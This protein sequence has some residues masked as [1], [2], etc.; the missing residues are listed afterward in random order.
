MYRF[1]FKKLFLFFFLILV[2]AA[3]FSQTASIR[4]FVYEK[5]SGEPV[6]FTNVFLKGTTFGAATDVNGYFSITKIPPGEYQLTVQALGF[7]SLGVIINLKA[8]EILTKKLFVTK[9]GINIKTIDVTAESQ[10]KKSD[11]KMSVTKITP[12]EIKVIP[13]VGG[14]P[15]LAQFIQVLP[16]VVFTGDQGGQL[17]IRGGTPIQNKVLLD[18]MIIYNP[19][20][21]IGM[22]SVFDTDIIRNTDVYTGGFGAEYGGRISS[23]MD[24]KTRDGNKKR[25]GG[26]VSA[27][28]FSAKLLFEG[29]IARAKSEN[30]GSASFIVSGKTSYLRH[31]SK[32]LY[33]YVDSNGLPYTFTDLYA[34][35]VLNNPNGSKINFFGFNFSDQVKYTDIAD[36]NWNSSGFG[37]SFVLVPGSSAVLIDGN[38][39]CSQYKIALDEADQKPRSSVINGFN[40]GLGFNYFLGRDELKYGLE[41]QGFK[42][43]FEFSNLANRKIEQ[44][45]NTTEVGAF[46][47]FK[48]VWERLVI[49]PGFRIQY[50]ASL[51][52]LSPEPRLGIKINAAKTLRFKLAGGYYSQNLLS[53]SSDRDVVNL[54]YGF[55]SGPDDLQEEFNEKKVN[56][57]LQKARH[58]I[59]GF[60]YD[61]PRHIDLNVECYYKKFDQLTNINRDKIYDD[62]S[63]N[64][65]KP[66]Y[67]KNSYVV[68]NGDAKGID[69]VLKYDYKRIYI[70]V[71]YSLAYV[72]RFD[73]IRNYMPTFDRRHNANVVGSYTFGK[74]LLW[75]FNARFN[76]GSGFPFTQTQ[77]YYEYLTFEGG[78][79]TDITDANGDLGIIYGDLNDG[80]LPNYFRLDLTLKRTF[81]LGKN[82]NLEVNASVINAA[83]RKNVF[84]I[85]RVTNQ[86]VDQ[87]PVIPSIG[88]NLTF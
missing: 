55:L 79:N 50:Y 22:F 84:Y 85:N 1:S 76:F 21:S 39:A 48:K 30:G 2:S 23:V 59:V 15:D 88:V 41:V 70:W 72:K 24:V 8:E 54:F 20:H 62:N 28:P 71:A 67:L 6:L 87:L 4:G 33:N 44:A 58:A 29:P 31:S 78:L 77:G 36:Y 61:F 80:K 5:E 68:E 64:N 32:A 27:N 11:V 53:T 82:S 10:E 12:R 18:G 65:Q 60:E 25:Y 42:T 83:N 73:G 34:K 17:Y 7:D 43:S 56:S 69:I 86:R 75:E 49:E 37:T 63:A 40:L 9:S 14:E 3:S 19:F 35:I 57:R 26:K 38:F 16:G 46:L 66:D 81:V 13:S 52:E 74:S 47:T 51:A 45:E